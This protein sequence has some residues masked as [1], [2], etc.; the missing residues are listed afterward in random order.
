MLIENL[1]QLD[2]LIEKLFTERSIAIDLESDT[3]KRFGKNISL[4][5]IGTSN[6]QFLIDC[7]EFD[8][9]NIRI[10][11][12][13]EQI[14]KIFFDGIQDIQ[15]L[16]E[17]YNWSIN[18]IFD[19]SDAYHFLWP[20]NQRK[21][22]STI[23]KELFNVNISKKLQRTDWSIRPL[24][25]D[26]MSYAASDVKY[27]IKLAE[28]LKEE[29]KTRNL[30]DK[31]LNYFMSFKLIQKTNPIIEEKFRFLLIPGFKEL[32]DFEK[33]IVKHLHK[34]RVNW[35]IGMNRPP[36]F[37]ISNKT[38]ILLAKYKPQ[39]IDEYE[40][41]PEKELHSRSLQKK[42]TKIVSIIKTLNDTYNSGKINYYQEI[43]IYEEKLSLIGRKY[44]FVLDKDMNLAIPQNIITFFKRKEKHLS[45]WVEKKSLE[46]TIP[47]ELFFSRFYIETLCNLDFTNNTHLPE[48]PGL[49]AEFYTLYGHEILDLLK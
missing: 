41:M 44:L 27:L 48:L 13:N 46:L 16:M 29:L 36:S 45:Q 35:G 7:Q 9:Q 19:V 22:L 11:F 42:Q 10:L 38:L 6:E 33:L 39:S 40:K 47:K 28:F 24:T 18:T 20:S 31:T 21:G 14:E 32:A 30:Y 8:I 34:Y 4:L 25:N 3:N 37:L 26:M 17:K 5:Q 23:L 43:G 49:N 1:H 12:E 15:M 2:N